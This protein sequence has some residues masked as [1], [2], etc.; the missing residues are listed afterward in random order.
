M[1]A[2]LCK[3]FGP[4]ESLVLEEVASPTAGPG[5]V[6][7]AIHACGVNFPD[8]L[9]LQ[10]KYQHKPPLPFAPGS[11]VAGTIKSVGA[12]VIGHKPGDRVMAYLMYGGCAEEVVADAG[13]LAPIP[14]R[15]DFVHASAFLMTYGTAFYA[16]NERARLQPGETLLVLGAAGGTGIAAIEVGKALGARVIAAASSADKLALARDH[17]A[18]QGIEYESEDLKQ[19]IRDLTAGQGADVIFDPVGGRYSEAALRS[20]AWNGRFIVIGF[21]AGDI[22]RIALNLPLLKGCAIV[23]SPWGAFLRRSR[24]DQQRHWR[25]LLELYGRGGLDPAV[26]ATYPLARAGEALREMME[27]RVKGKVAIVVR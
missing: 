14:E 3:A 17:G 24:E 9:V 12:G 22:P 18:D 13:S 6:V 7:I 15:L 19:R 21:A 26:T 20:I 5:Q 2:L 1:K 10:N 8:V 23:G 11:E 16:L 4:P 25:E 27:R